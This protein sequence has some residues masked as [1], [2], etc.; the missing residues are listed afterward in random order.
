MKRNIFIYGLINSLTG[1]IFY[2]GQTKRPKARLYEHLKKN[3]SDKNPAKKMLVQSILDNGGNVLYVEI[4][5]TDCQIEA[6][7]LESKYIQQ[8]PNLVNMMFTKLPSRKGQKA[9][10]ETK[11]KMFNSSPLK[12]KVAMVSS[13]NIIIEIFDGVREANRKTN[14]DHRSIS[15]VAAG[16]AIR[17]TAGGYKWQYV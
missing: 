1:E 16:S 8:Y 5:K 3:S 13:D 10:D 12:K 17:K 11:Q 14:I 4:D 9:S 15:A 6:N 2:I 7:T